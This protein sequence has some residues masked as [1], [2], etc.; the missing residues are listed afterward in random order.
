MIYYFSH[1]RYVHADVDTCPLKPPTQ[2]PSQYIFSLDS[3]SSSSSSSSPSSSSCS[4]S[5]ACPSSMP[6]SLTLS[7]QRSCLSISSSSSSCSSSCSSPSSSSPCAACITR[8]S[9]R[10]WLCF[11]QSE[12]METRTYYNQHP[13]QQHNPLDTCL[14]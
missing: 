12:R 8:R 11:N 10:A 4:S 5:S 13:K 2:F 1:F 9:L 3:P 14:V 6:S 7:P